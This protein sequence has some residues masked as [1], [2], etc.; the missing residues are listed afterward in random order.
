MGV[1]RRTVHRMLAAAFLTTLACSA[2]AADDA[3]A[4]PTRPITVVVGY[5]PGGATDMISVVVG[6]LI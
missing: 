1:T 5:P 6:L 4:Y 2:V 3:G